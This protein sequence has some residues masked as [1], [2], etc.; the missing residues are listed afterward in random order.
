MCECGVDAGIRSFSQYD[1][2]LTASYMV[3]HYCEHML[4]AVDRNKI[5]GVAGTKRFN[6]MLQRNSPMTGKPRQ[7]AILRNEPQDEA[8][9][10]V[11]K[12]SSVTYDRPIYGLS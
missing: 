2:N 4:P 12:P 11:L 6:F 9:A 3:K 5:T 10:G 7:I 1:E 8:K